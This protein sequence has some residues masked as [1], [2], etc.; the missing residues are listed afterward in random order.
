MWTA[1][2]KMRRLCVFHG[3]DRVQVYS[4]RVPKVHVEEGA[5][6]FKEKGLLV[7]SNLGNRILSI[8]LIQKSFWDGRL[9]R[10]WS[11]NYEFRC[12]RWA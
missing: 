1:H 11:R 9:G 12:G 8:S 5:R 10:A 7:V 6:S 3:S 2:L 4:R